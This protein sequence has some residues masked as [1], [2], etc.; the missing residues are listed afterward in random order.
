[1]TPDI[2]ES[3]VFLWLCI[4]RSSKTVDGTTHDR[5]GAQSTAHGRWM[6]T[7]K[8]VSSRSS[9]RSLARTAGRQAERP[10]AELA[11]LPGRRSGPNDGPVPAPGLAR[12]EVTA[13]RSDGVFFMWQS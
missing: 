13:S 11:E 7:S 1:M 10:A 2:A 5:D 12:M 8:T 4:D 6:P 9:I 3:F